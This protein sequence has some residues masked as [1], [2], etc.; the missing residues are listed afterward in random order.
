MATLQERSQILAHHGYSRDVIAA[1]LGITPAEV[2]AVSANPAASVTDPSGGSAAFVAGTPVVVD[3]GIDFVSGWSTEADVEEAGMQAAD[4]TKAAFVQLMA[5]GAS[6]S[7]DAFIYLF[8]EKPLVLGDAVALQAVS[9]NTEVG[10]PALFNFCFVLPAGW[11]Y[12]PLAS[13]DTMQSG[14]NWQFPLG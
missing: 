2:V 9:V 7:T 10:T 3:E 14:T 4:P 8:P 1:M 11:W 5:K 12:A 6:D 13:G